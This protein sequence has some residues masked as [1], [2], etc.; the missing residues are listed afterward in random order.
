MEN[1]IHHGFDQMPSGGMICIAGRLED[2][3][4]ILEISDN[5]KGIGM[6][7]LNDRDREKGFHMESFGLAN[8]DERIKLYFGREYGISI[9]GQQRGTRI[10][11]ELPA[12]E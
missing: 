7:C 5:G 1:A 11:I 9:V 2:H 3:K 12:M 8:T 4:V 10:R 6:D